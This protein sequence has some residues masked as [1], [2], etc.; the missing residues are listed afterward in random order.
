MTEVA[1][2]RPEASAYLDDDGSEYK[3]LKVQKSV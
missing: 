2:L 3:K 1:A